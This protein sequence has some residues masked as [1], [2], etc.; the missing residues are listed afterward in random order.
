MLKS[1]S[2]HTK[3]RPITCLR[4]L[5]PSGVDSKSTINSRFLQ[6]INSSLLLVS[7][8][9]SSPIT[10]QLVF[11]GA[12]LPPGP[13]SNRAQWPFVHFEIPS[14]SPPCTSKLC[15]ALRDNCG[16]I[17]PTLQ[18]SHMICT[19]RRRPNSQESSSVQ[20]SMVR[21]RHL[22]LHARSPVLTMIVRFVLLGAL[23][24][25]FF[26]CMAALL[27]PVHRRKEGIKW[28]A[29]SYTMASFLL[30]TVRLAAE[31]DIQSISYI[32]NREFPGIKG[33]L[34]PG[35]LGYQS[36][37]Y[38]HVLSIIPNLACVLNNLLA[39][40]LLVSSLFD[41]SGPRCI[42]PA[43]PLALSLLRGLRREALDRRLSLPRIP[44]LF[45][46]VFEFP[47]SQRRRFGLTQPEL[48]Q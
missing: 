46:C 35:P 47:T 13:L 39:D 7:V 2:V 34:P 5:Y 42:T 3:S 33:V 18:R 1:K 28:G 36:L 41:R 17:T 12:F 4:S 11:S 8:L 23:A 43:P 21:S 31:F 9:Y 20:F 37:I 38:S 24:V 27:N 44:R 22:H 19:L 48:M 40:G 32:D 6:R 26:Q 10:V 29:V 14:S 15:L 25:L 45:G 30:A 16:L